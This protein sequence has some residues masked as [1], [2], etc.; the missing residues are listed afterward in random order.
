LTWIVTWWL[1]AEALGLLT[2]PIAF[3]VFRRLYDRG[4]TFAKILGLV[5][6]GFGVWAGGTSGLLPNTR[7]TVLAILALVGLLSAVL[8]WIQ[9]RALGE[10]L[11]ERY[12]VLVA[13]DVVLLGFFLL[14]VVLRSY[15]PGVSHTEQPMDFAFLNAASRASTFPPEDPWLSGHAINYYYFGYV[16]WAVFAK[17]ASTPISIAYN[18]ALPLSLGLAATGAFG[19]VFNLVQGASERVRDRALAFG[20]LG[21]A[22]VLLVGNLE[23]L[24]ELAYAHGLGTSGFWSWLGIKGLAVPYHSGSWYP[25]EN[26]WWWKAT[27]VIDTL[28]NGQSRDYTITEF[29]FFS[30]LL[31]DLHPHVTALPLGLLSLGL[32]LELVRHPGGL[33]RTWIASNLGLLA[34]TSLVIGALGFANSWDL[35][36]YGGLWL[37][38]LGVWGYSTGQRWW[39]LRALAVGGAVLVGAMTLYLPFYARFN[40]QA[41]GVWPMMALTTRP[42]HYLIV[43]GAFLL[44]V[45]YL[46]LTR[47]KD[48]VGTSRRIRVLGLGVA[49]AP[50]FAWTIIAL[51]LTW[52]GGDPGLWEVVWRWVKLAPLVLGVTVALCLVLADARRQ[53]TKRP[54]TFALLLAAIGLVVTYVPELFYIRDLFGNRMNTMFKLYYQA[55]AI[56]PLAAAYALSVWSRNASRPSDGTGVI[57]L[58][59]SGDGAGVHHEHRGA[60]RT[61]R[62]WGQ[63]VGLGLAMTLVLAGAAYPA[64]AFVSRGAAG[65]SGFTLDALA[66]QAKAKPGEYAAVQWLLAQRGT[67][68]VLEAVGGSYTGYGRISAMTGLPTVLGWTGHEHQWRGTRAFE[69]READ[70]DEAYRIPDSARTLAVLHKYNVRY[71][72]VGDLERSRYGAA[73][74]KFQAGFPVAFSAP[75]ATIYEV[76]S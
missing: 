20:L 65:P 15:D 61:V 17:I 34:V 38:C 49:A 53:E 13:A 51:G 58:D 33:G 3:V 2:F 26:W 37:A 29:P 9:R 52:F 56:I 62:Y 36:T 32:S 70:V 60:G 6:V 12:L 45:A 72:Y 16:L 50:L 23:G 69:G 43:W 35:P 76:P 19:I 24:L 25:T 21:A 22:L 54:Q 8:A 59:A 64:A 5:L 73:L 30:F 31:G 39:W 57:V 42:V 67:P 10:F 68:V 71:V 7:P 18:L 44:P 46:L 14:G 47:W 4:Y 27:R 1:G 40:P 28:A 66:P 75:G 11:R 48:L 63:R 55:W 74:D 41:N